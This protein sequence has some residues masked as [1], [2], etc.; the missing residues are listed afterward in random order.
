MK[1]TD[2]SFR[3]LGSIS[4]SS[5]QGDNITDQNAESRKVTHQ[6]IWP[7]ILVFIGLTIPTTFSVLVLAS[8]VRGWTFPYSTYN[9]ITRNRAS[10][11]LVI[12]LLS[13]GLALVNTTILCNLINRATRI[14]WKNTPASLNIIRFWNGLCVRSIDWTIPL[15]LLLPLLAFI[16]LTAAP[17]AIWVGALTPVAINVTSYN[18]I[19]I[20]TYGQ[21]ANIK[22]WPSEIGAQGPILSTTQGLF[23][24]SVALQLQ[25]SLLTAASSATTVDGSVRQHAKLDKSRFTY[26]GRSYGVGASVGLNDLDF[27][28]NPY[29]A[30]TYQ[31]IGFETTVTCIKNSSSE[32]ML[33]ETG[34]TFL[35]RAYGRLPNS[36]NKGP[37]DSVYIGHSTDSILAIGVGRN[38]EDP[39][40]MLAI[41]AGDS[42]AH[43]NTTQCSMEFQPTIFD[44]DVD[45]R[46]RNISV[47][48][49]RKAD[50]FYPSS[51]NLTQTAMRQFEL[52][53]NVQTNMYASVL[54]NAFNSS[55]TDYITASTSQAITLEDATLPGLENALTV[56]LDDM[57]V[58]YASA[59]LI[60]QKDIK[61]VNMQITKSALRVGEDVYIYAIFAINAFIILLVIMEYV[62]TRNWKEVP[63]IDYLDPG[64]LMVGSAT[65]TCSLEVPKTL[66]RYIK[67]RRSGASV[68]L[69]VHC[70]NWIAT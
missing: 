68:K 8:S 38:P 9:F 52:I 17:S 19:D 37:E 15:H 49:L 56:M 36:G 34:D 48:P 63:M 51:S 12:Q 5:L 7:A 46:T 14:R 55:I 39:R 3:D 22:E 29:L 21:T 44:V 65:G 41:T 58:A 61:P 26:F 54:G 59:Q 16:V 18:V 57:L 24:Y 35:Y 25:A 13:N 20:P 32:F 1:Y 6:T 47:T 66:S 28:K 60:I 11:Q 10:V 4:S 62:R 67:F 64:A 43:L 53:S 42:Y 23:S 31:E 40:R 70:Q 33:M 30:Y 50:E 27:Q 45:I 2:V 69:Q